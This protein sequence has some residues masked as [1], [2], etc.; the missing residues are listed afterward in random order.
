MIP[1]EHDEQV[2]LIQWARA[3]S[4]GIPEL[5][6]LLAIPNGGARHKVVAAKLRAEG[7]RAGV[8]DL[9]LPVPRGSHHGLWVELK[10]IKGGVISEAQA[11]WIADLQLQGYAV[12]VCKGWV[13]AKDTIIDYLGMEVAA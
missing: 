4:A 9:F 2:A 8:P 6:M 10:R 5:A 11:G 13:A 7:V 3:Q 12:E 1:T